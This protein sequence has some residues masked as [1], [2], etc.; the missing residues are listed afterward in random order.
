MCHCT[1]VK[2]TVPCVVWPLAMFVNCVCTMWCSLLQK[3]TTVHFRSRLAT[4]VYRAEGYSTMS[5]S[6]LRK[7]TV[8]KGTVPCHA[9]CYESVPCWRVQYHVM[10]SATKVYRAEGYSTMSCS[11]LRKCTVLKGTVPCHA[12]CYESVPCR[13]GSTMSVKQCTQLCN[14]ESAVLC[15]SGSKLNCTTLKLH[16]WWPVKLLHCA[17]PSTHTTTVIHHLMAGI[18]SEKCVVRQFR[19]RANIIECTYTNLHSIVYDTRSLCGIVYC[20]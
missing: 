4:K 6:L 5:C 3:C 11:L 2:G 7:C 10:Q 18:R 19:H 1:M 9:V 17:S 14:A 20:S 12:V 13:R 8:L 16:Y 15:Y